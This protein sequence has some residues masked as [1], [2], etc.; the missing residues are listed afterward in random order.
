MVVPPDGV[1]QFPSMT[2]TVTLSPSQDT[3]STIVVWSM[4]LVGGGSSFVWQMNIRS[5]GWGM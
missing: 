2:V 4:D 5:P 3:L 1:L